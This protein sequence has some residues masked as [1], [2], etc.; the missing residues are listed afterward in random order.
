MP[1]LNTSPHIRYPVL[2][3]SLQ[4]RAGTAQ[5]DA[6]AWGFASAADARGVDIIQKC[7]VTG[8]RREN[9]RITGV[10][11]SRGFIRGKKG[12]A[13]NGWEHQYAGRNGGIRLPLQTH[14]LQAMV[15]EPVAP[16][17]DSVIMSNAVHAYISQ[18]DKGPL[19]IGAGIDAYSGF[20][21]RGSLSVVEA[22]MSA[23]VE[24][25]PISA[26]CG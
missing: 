17:L 3:A 10:D 18:A 14:P 11:T 25:F 2:G 16:V 15:S 9:G 26:G 23:I 24:L 21:L 4:R 5:H 7:E 20:G 13:G 8:I 1:I 22:A 12:G 6:V 19:V